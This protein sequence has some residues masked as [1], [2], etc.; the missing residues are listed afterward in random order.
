MRAMRRDDSGRTLK[1]SIRYSGVQAPGKL[2]WPAVD[3][4]EA[5]DRETPGAGIVDDH[6][7]VDADQFRSR[8]V[9]APLQLPDL[10]PAT[11]TVGA[12]HCHDAV[13]HL[14]HTELV[15]APNAREHLDDLGSSGDRLL[16]RDLP[17]AVGCPRIAK[18]IGIGAK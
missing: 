7:V 2:D 3:E 18:E 10:P 1:S 4:L 14:L 15:E 16:S 17:A 8:A 11:A 13:E 12:L 9:G 5:A 6:V